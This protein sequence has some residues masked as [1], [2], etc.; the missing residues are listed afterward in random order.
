MMRRYL[1]ETTITVAM[2]QTYAVVAESSEAALE[3][4]DEEGPGGEIALV[5]EEC[6]NVIG[7]REIGEVT[8]Q[9]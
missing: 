9:G 8:E 3:R 1:I 6:V 2:L 4:F 5:S 7:D